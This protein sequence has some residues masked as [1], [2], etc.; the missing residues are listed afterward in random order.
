MTA[1]HQPAVNRVNATLALSIAPFPNRM[2]S[3]VAKLNL[4]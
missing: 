3:L 4:D 2:V 1:I